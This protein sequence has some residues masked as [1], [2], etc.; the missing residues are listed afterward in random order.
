MKVIFIP[1]CFEFSIIKK[2]ET[3]VAEEDEWE[4]IPTL[5]EKM[6]D[7]FIEDVPERS[8]IIERTHKT[9]THL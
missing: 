5:G 9:N 8:V 4:E 7:Q 1:S 2:S 6:E 3:G